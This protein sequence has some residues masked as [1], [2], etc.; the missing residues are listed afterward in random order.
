MK[1]FIDNDWSEYLNKTFGDMEVIGVFKKPK[2]DKPGSDTWLKLRCHVCKHERDVNA[3]MFKQ[4]YGRNHKTACGF[5]NK[6]KYDHLVGTDVDDLHICNVHKGSNRGWAA[7]VKCNVCGHEK[8]IRVEHLMEH[9]GTYHKSCSFKNKQKYD[10]LIGKTFEDMTVQSIFYEDPNYY[11]HV[12]CNVCGKEKDMDVHAIQKLSGTS[13]SFCTFG[14]Y[15]VKFNHIY[16]G[17]CERT[18]NPKNHA[19][20][21]Y[22]GRGIRCEWK[23]LK[24]F[25]DDMLESYSEALELFGEGNVS[26]ERVN[27]NG[28]Y[29]KEN[30][31]WIRKIDQFR[32]K[33]N[34][35]FFM[36][37]DPF[38]NVYCDRDLS[39]FCRNHHLM[40]ES[41]RDVVNGKIKEHHGWTGHRITRKE[42]ETYWNTQIIPTNMEYVWEAFQYCYQKFKDDEK[43]RTSEG[44]KISLNAVQNV[45]CMFIPM[46]AIDALC[47]QENTLGLDISYDYDKKMFCVAWTNSDDLTEEE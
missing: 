33:T 35:A 38:G 24:E 45:F 34:T 22:G 40:R 46:E 28:N 29:C 30:C 14:L 21:D 12:K 7:H 11:A 9:N 3:Y 31:L 32:N 13:H 17:I 16:R 37:H 23:E 2:G 27:V 39:R 20:K 44:I 47:N 19:Y 5:F 1:K 8:N 36:I 6:N 41:M 15:P 26:I 43:H 18:G 25:A 42:Y 10:Y 4:G